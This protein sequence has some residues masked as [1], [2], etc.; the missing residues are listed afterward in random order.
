MQEEAACLTYS[1]PSGSEFEP[2][3]HHHH[4]LGGGGG[5]SLFSRSGYQPRPALEPESSTQSGLPQFHPLLVHQVEH[6]HHQT[7]GTA[8]PYRSG[9]LA[10]DL[11]RSNIVQQMLT[12]ISTSVG[13]EEVL[14]FNVGSGNPQRTSGESGTS[15]LGLHVLFEGRC[16]SGHSLFCNKTS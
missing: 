4:F 10:V 6:P 13:T 15:L 11:Q 8:T 2:L 14:S 12:N 7:I 9:L 1:L 3:D 16:C 5:F